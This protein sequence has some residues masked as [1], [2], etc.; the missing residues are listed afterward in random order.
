M[1]LGTVLPNLGAH[2]GPESILR[3]A[4][5][6]ESLG[7]DS[8]WVA[9]RILYPL[10]PRT[11]YG[12]TP[13]GSLPDFY[14]IAYSPL[15]T[16]TWAAA[17]TS[18]IRI[19][20]SVLNIPMHQPVQLA[21]ELA[22]LDAFSGGR[23]SVGLGQGW[24]QDEY[25][26]TGA[27]TSKMGPRADEFIEV[28]KAMWGPDPVEFNGEYFTVPRSN[29][30]PKPVQQPY[31]PIYL[32]AYSPTALARAGRLANGWL[33]TG[34]PLTGVAQM[35]EGLHRAASE[36][37]RDPASLEILVLGHV[38]LTETPLG[39]GRANF[40]G[41]LD[42]IREDF[43]TAQQIGVSEVILSPT[44]GPLVNAPV[45]DQLRFL[46]QMRSLV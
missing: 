40:M 12:G 38:G 24:S 5:H 20:T 45:D 30:N 33:P 11:P 19:G 39:E 44:G 36:A 10:S 9:E 8:L 4:Q 32:A 26:A 13:D 35:T 21:K 3:V 28:L 25:E 7:F 2:A 46:D 15:I 31:P 42:E 6:A 41:T 17:H 29:I 22:S 18:T 23:L 27:I 14:L 16:L 1:R 43:E 37:G 34:I